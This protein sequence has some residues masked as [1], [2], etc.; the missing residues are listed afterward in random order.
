MK[1]FGYNLVF[2]FA[3]C[4]GVAAQA[5]QFTGDVLG[6]HNLSPT[7]NSPVKGTSS[8]ACLYCHAPH[9]GIGGATPL[10]AHTLSS[11]TYSLYSGSPGGNVGTQPL[12]GT[13]S[14]LCLSCHDGTVAVG[15]LVP[16]GN[17]NVTGA[18]AGKD[19]LGIN[20]KNSHPFS[21]KKPLVDAPN[22]VATLA[23]TGKTADPLNKVA[24]VGGTVECTSCHEPHVQN[25][26]PVSLTFLVRDGSS[27]QL[28]LACH[29]PNNRTVNGKNNPLAQWSTSIHAVSV[30]N[31][32]GAAKLGSYTTVAQFACMSCHDAHNASGD[33]GL[34]RSAQ[35]PPSNVDPA[36]ATC[37]TCHN[38]GS[39]LQQPIP[40]VYAEFAKVSAHPFPNGGNSHDP[41]EAAVLTN[42]RHATCADC[43]NAHS[44]AQVLTFPPAP[45]IRGTQG[46]VTGVSATDGTTQVSPAA[47]QYEN[48]LRCHGSSPGK[49]AQQVYGYMPLRAVS[50]ADPLNVIPEFS[51][52]STS[53]HPVTHGSTSPWP[54]PSLL[55][56]LLNLDGS[57][58]NIRSLGTTQANS[59]FCTDCHN[60]DDNREFG[61]SG[62]SGP[63]GSQWTHI[64]ER[65]YE[66]SQVAAGAAPGTPVQ[67]PFP[68][69]SLSASAANPGPYALCGKCHNL[70][71]ILLDA[72]F[73][74]AGTGKGGH[75]TH[76]SEQGLS[77]STCHTAHGMG[78]AGGAITGERMVNFDLKVVGPNGAT[79]ISYN[80]GTNTCTLKCHG[81][82][83]N[84][85]GTVTTTP[86]P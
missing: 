15:Q 9:S 25:L 2:I 49:Q 5:P 38:G 80:H 32:A 83:H 48:C 11:Q 1:R 39:N 56:F 16:Y 74:P 24:L 8:A 72:S 45:T 63:H 21:L 27:G 42:N 77:C 81:Y 34:L 71:N 23:A 33:R 37:F 70:A 75:F 4:C 19:V 26:D 13:P 41:G 10:W 55:L 61:G 58:N 17:V 14:V 47:N 73:R 54:Q 18:M 46:A 12:L 29:E 35:A 85:S 69:P 78:A 43:H 51:M 7:G 53:S 31:V 44:T 68:S 66:F 6:T 82:Y 86:G 20:L 28:C 50:A 62:P 84:P 59:I 36:S 40:N 79:P 65:R 76:V 57:T 52:T 22:L 67:N 3:L 60:S 30:N 64:L